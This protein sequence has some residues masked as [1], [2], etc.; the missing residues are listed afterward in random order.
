M[1]RKVEFQRGD[2]VAHLMIVGRNANGPWIAE[3]RVHLADAEAEC[4]RA[5][6]KDAMTTAFIHNVSAY[7][8][9][10]PQGMNHE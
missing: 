4:L 2:K 3:P 1:K 8:G 9:P 10:Q 5:M 6:N 7:N